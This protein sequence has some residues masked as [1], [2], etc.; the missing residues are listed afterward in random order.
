[1]GMDSSFQPKHSKKYVDLSSIIGKAIKT[2]GN[3]VRDGKFP[4]DNESFFLP[5]DI[6][7]NLINNI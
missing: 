7:D 6:S 4:T 5:K 3:D 2:Y 1:L